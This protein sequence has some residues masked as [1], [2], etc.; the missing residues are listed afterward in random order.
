MQHT[1][2]ADH[3]IARNQEIQKADR[4]K[5]KRPT[6]L[7]S[8]G[9]LNLPKSHLGGEYWRA[10]K[11]GMES[12]DLL[13]AKGHDVRILGPSCERRGI[14]CVSPWFMFTTDLEHR[15]PGSTLSLDIDSNGVSHFAIMW[16][17]DM[18][19]VYGDLVFAQLGSEVEARKILSALG[20]PPSVVIETSTLGEGGL[21]ARSGKTLILSEAVHR[22]GIRKGEIRS[23]EHRRYHIHFLP[24]SREDFSTG[25]E[26]RKDPVDHIDTEF[27]LVFSK[28]GNALA[29][30]NPDYYKQFRRPIDQLI[31]KIDASL[32]IAPEGESTMAVN[33][34]SLP[35]GKV[36]IA[37][38][39]DSTQSFLE[40][41]LGKENVTVLPIDPEIYLKG[42]GLRCMSNV[43][44]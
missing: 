37:S 18:F 11:K 30:V 24:A 33:F 3:R 8:P 32:H 44:E 34:I 4:R 28:G 31:K 10:L 13:K 35:N 40:R 2:S 22:R 43:I 15:R 39:C 9:A 23:L 29:C 38:D 12:Y 26:R 16:P 17:R 6:I 7:L 14:V 5:G 42:G 27:G 25:M 41:G 20:F 19:Q 1:T 21:V 36:I